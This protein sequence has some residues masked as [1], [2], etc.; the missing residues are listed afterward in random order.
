MNEQGTG[1]DLEAKRKSDGRPTNEAETNQ[2]LGDFLEGPRNRRFETLEVLRIAREFIRGFRKFHFLGPTV[3][4]FGSAR[5]KE[6]HEYYIMARKMGRRIADAGFVTMTGGGPGI[7]EAANR[8]A[9]EANG[10]SVGS[11]IVLPFEQDANPYVDLWV[12]F[13]YFFVRKLMLLK[14]SQAF[15]IMPGGFGTL[16]ELFE[17]STLIQTGKLHDFPLVLMGHAFWD[18]L[19]DYIQETMVRVGTIG[20]DDHDRFLV[21]DSTEEAIAYILKFATESY[22]LRWAPRPRPRWFLGEQAGARDSGSGR[23]SS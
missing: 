18:P 6:D 13:D 9:K 4:V 5:F 20:Q 12:D 23:A 3:T 2:Y 19:L 17:T 7:M 8:G 22:G 10:L 1:L 21:T 14:Y 15:V 16:D 11:N